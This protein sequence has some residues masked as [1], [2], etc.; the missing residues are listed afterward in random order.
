MKHLKIFFLY[1]I[2]FMLQ[3]LS[4][5]A[6]FESTDLTA[7]NVK[8]GEASTSLVTGIGNIYNNPAGLA[9]LKKREV[10]ILYSKM[11]LNLEADD[12]TYLDLVA[13]YPLKKFTLAGSFNRFS[14]QLYFEQ[15]FSLAGAV[16]F[17]DDKEKAVSLGIRTKLLQ[18]GYIRND[19]TALDSLFIENGYNKFGVSLDLGLLYESKN[20]FNFGLCFKNVNPP[21][22]T[23]D[24]GGSGL[25]FVFNAGLSYLWNLWRMQSGSF[26]KSLL[27]SCDTSFKSEDYSLHFGAESAL[28]SGE[29]MPG[30]G[31]VV[32]SGHLAYFTAG[33]SYRPRDSSADSKSVF[34][35]IQ[36]VCYAFR[37]YLGGMSLGT[38]GDHFISMNFWF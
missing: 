29:F 15:I 18:I 8:L 23:L 2:L 21:V 12:L 7:E 16:K 32:G 34:N 17:I 19:Y 36:S 9:Q 20:G 22:M 6:A 3:C 13:G 1:N 4:A 24:A 30:A 31:F 38:Y 10:G 26:V 35:H 11:M 27:L 14:S 28:G 33:L 25:P 5:F 37:F